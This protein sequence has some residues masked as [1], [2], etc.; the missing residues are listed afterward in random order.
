MGSQNLTSG[1]VAFGILPDNGFLSQDPK[2]LFHSFQLL[3]PKRSEESNEIQVPINLLNAKKIKKKHTQKVE[4]NNK[5]QNL[6]QGF[7]GNLSV[8]TLI[9]LLLLVHLLPSSAICLPNPLLLHSA[10]RKL[11]GN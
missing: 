10:I 8:T 6:F 3:A 11:Y 9:F 7:I 5:K 1:G 4:T 2:V